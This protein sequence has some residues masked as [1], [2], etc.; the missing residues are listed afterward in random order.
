MCRIGRPGRALAEPVLLDRWR[1][2]ER[3]DKDERR[4]IYVAMRRIGIPVPA[5]VESAE[6]R[7]R[8]ERGNKAGP[9]VK[10]RPPP[11]EELFKDWGDVT[12]SSHPRVCSPK[13]WQA[14]REEQYGGT[15]RT[16]LD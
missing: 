8:R 1:K 2:L 15:R 3:H 5:L 10:Q 14:R 16:N 4:A 9:G 12:P 11:M 6:E 7:E 13:E